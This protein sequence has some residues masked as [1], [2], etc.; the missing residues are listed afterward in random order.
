M[1]FEN[2]LVAPPPNMKCFI[3]N[4]LLYKLV[5]EYISRYEYERVT[6]NVSV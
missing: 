2:C 6:N 4:N 3:K 5:C 1:A